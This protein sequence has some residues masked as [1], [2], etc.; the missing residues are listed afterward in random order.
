MKKRILAIVLT[1]FGVLSFSGC[2]ALPLIVPF[3]MM[4][5]G[6][7]GTYYETD[8]STHEEA[9]EYIDAPAFFPQAIEDY[10]IN[11]YS[12]TRY[13]Y[14]DTCVEL[15][16]DLTVT[17][18]Q[19]TEILTNARQ[20]GKRFVERE[21]YY[22]EGYYEIV[23]SDEYSLDETSENVGNA[24]VQKIIY[25]IETGNVIYEHFDAF[26]TGVYEVKDVAYF[27][28]FDIDQTEYVNHTID[29]NNGVLI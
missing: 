18:E 29:K 24:Y 4:M 23:F 28:R 17:E 1:V 12:W 25:N 15:F 6:G 27:N 26:D 13:E 8:P 11:E 2:Q 10:T 21:T 20:A 22:A 16:I 9:L 3:L 7:M 14:M 5:G 19:L